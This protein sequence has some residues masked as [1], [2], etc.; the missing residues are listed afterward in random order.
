[1]RAIARAGALPGALLCGGI[2]CGAVVCGAGPAARAAGPVV[3][4]GRAR[5]GETVVVTG[6]CPA[7]DRGVRVSGAAA[8]EGAVRGGRF[9]VEARVA[10]EA[11]R[12]PVTAWCVPSGRAER[13]PLEV[14]GARRPRPHGW[15]MPGDDGFA[16]PWTSVALVLAVGAA[17]AGAAALARS[18]FRRV[19]GRGQARP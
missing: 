3:T 16:V 18:R 11:G 6:S 17:G 19:R 8:G 9:R 15:T 13:A 12:R 1:M 5:P 2:V 14:Q 10:R 4:P 7:G